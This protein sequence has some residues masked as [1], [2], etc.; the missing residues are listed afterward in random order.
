MAVIAHLAESDRLAFHAVQLATSALAKQMVSTLR[1]HQSVSWVHQAQLEYH[2][3]RQALQTGKEL[4][5]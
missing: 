1:N 5:S 2:H 3:A 4:P